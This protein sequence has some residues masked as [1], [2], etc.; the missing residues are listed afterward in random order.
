MTPSLFER[1]R[2]RLREM[3]RHRD[4][5]VGINRRNVTLVYAHNP[6]Q[7]YPQADDKLLC[8]ELMAKHGVGLAR[9]LAVCDGLSGIPAVL[10]QLDTLGDFVVKP[11]TSSGGDGIIVVGERLRAGVWRAPGGDGKKLITR[12]DVRHRLAEIVFGAF[13]GDLEDRAFVEERV[14]PHPVF[15]SLWGE[16]LCDIRIITLETTPCFAMVRVPTRESAGRANLHQGGIGLALDIDS[17]VT[18]RAWYRGRSVLHH[19]EGGAS[20]VGVQMP[21][22]GIVLDTARR[23][24]RA[25]SLGYLGVDVVVDARG[26]PLVLEVNARPGLEIQNVHGRGLGAALARHAS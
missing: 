16:G 23:A 14:V 21:N 2:A 26:A 19:P 1:W 12:D 4:E 7:N 22:W 25:I 5:L 9:T 10:Q 6:R 18:T 11:A 24:A 3:S 13:S 15:H 17:G 8:K 20:L